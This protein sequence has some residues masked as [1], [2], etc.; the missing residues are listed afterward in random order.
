M[1]QSHFISSD[2][3]LNSCRSTSVSSPFVGSSNLDIIHDKTLVPPLF[4]I[5]LCKAMQRNLFFTFCTS[6]G[7]GKTIFPVEQINSYYFLF[8]RVELEARIKF[9]T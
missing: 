8:S 6:G 1:T 5:H 4:L 3:E 2:V 7:G 9:S